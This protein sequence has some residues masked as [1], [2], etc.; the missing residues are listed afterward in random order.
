MFSIEAVNDP[1]RRDVVHARLR[2][3]NAEHSSVIRALGG[4]SAREAVPLHVFATGPDGELAGGAIGHLQWHWLHLELL[5]VDARHR[6]SGLGS[7]LVA[8]AEEEART[9]HGAVGSQV[10]TW[11]FQ[12]PDFYRRLGYELVATIDDYPPG[13]AN[14]LLTKRFGS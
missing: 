5:W 14:H 3:S 7:R 12:A 4:T 9:V 11:D 1:E 10:E 8:R 6:G 13:V 2:A